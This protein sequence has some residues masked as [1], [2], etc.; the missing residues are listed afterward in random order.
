VSWLI[1]IEK[2]EWYLNEV[3]RGL[4]KGDLHS[5]T[6]SCLFLCMQVYALGNPFGLDHSL[7]QVGL[8][9]WRMHSLMVREWSCGVVLQYLHTC[10]GL[11]GLAHFSS[12]NLYVPR[13]SVCSTVLAGLRTLMCKTYS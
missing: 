7:T 3:R 13:P 12:F 2:L 5:M 8:Q 9:V 10:T 1:M 11:P 4:S 6:A